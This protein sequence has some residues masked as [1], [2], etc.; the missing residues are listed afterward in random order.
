MA[1][2][3]HKSQQLSAGASVNVFQEAFLFQVIA[4]D[5][6]GLDLGNIVLDA[7]SSQLAGFVLS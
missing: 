2:D 3:Y 7:R 6:L 5:T 4:Y 1:A